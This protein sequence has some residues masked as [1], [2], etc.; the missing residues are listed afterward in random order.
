MTQYLATFGST[1]LRTEARRLYVTRPV[2]DVAFVRGS[3]LF[4][5]GRP[6]IM[7]RELLR[8]IVEEERVKGGPDPMYGEPERKFKPVY[9]LAPWVPQPPDR[10]G[11]SIPA[12]GGE[13]SDNTTTVSTK[14][15]SNEASTQGDVQRVVSF[16]GLEV[17][18][19]DGTPLEA[20]AAA[21]LL[22]G[23]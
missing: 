13:L 16:A 2:T 1:P 18:V 6:V 14:G 21:L 22:L 20:V 23:G 17:E 9:D 12:E 4:A 11:R 10:S 19:K 3:P 15:E 8:V 7:R 5:F